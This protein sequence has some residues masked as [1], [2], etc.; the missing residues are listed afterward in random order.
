LIAAA[1]VLVSASG[2]AAAHDR[3]AFSIGVGVPAPVVAPAP[4]YYP[5]APVYYTPPPVVY[6]PPVYYGPGYY[7]P[8]VSVGFVSGWGHG[9]WRHHR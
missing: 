1:A 2:V 5:P 6:A 3:V 4:V 8:R 7:V 9:H